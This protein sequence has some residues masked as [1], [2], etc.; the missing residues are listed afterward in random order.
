VDWLLEG[1]G[2]MSDALGYTSAF[3]GTTITAGAANTKG[4]YAATPLSTSTPHDAQGVMIFNTTRSATAADY[5]VDIALGAS[6]SERIVIPNL[7]LGAVAE[8]LLS[9]QHPGR[10]APERALPEFDG[11]GD[12]RHRRGD[13]AGVLLGV[14]V[15]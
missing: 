3:V 1:I 12:D 14:H 9:A 8:L 2:R 6:G 13:R 4:S 5:L 15:L 10:V 7:K 11:F